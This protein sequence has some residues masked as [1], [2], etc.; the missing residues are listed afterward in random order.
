MIKKE[1][2]CDMKERIETLEGNVSTL[3]NLVDSLQIQIGILQGEVNLKVDKDSVVSQI[4]L[5]DEDIR[6]NGNKLTIDGETIIMKD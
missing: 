1:F 4:N 2:K 3:T 5:S 6:V